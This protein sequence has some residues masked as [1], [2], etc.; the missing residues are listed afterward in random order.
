MNDT[1]RNKDV[2]L[3]NDLKT[4]ELAESSVA[5]ERESETVK[6]HNP[7]EM[8]QQNNETDIEGSSDIEYEDENATDMPLTYLVP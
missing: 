3:E 6:V 8:Y 2:D 4:L 1:T 5:E 7:E